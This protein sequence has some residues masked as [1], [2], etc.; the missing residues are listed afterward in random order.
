MY[1]T[2]TQYVYATHQVMFF[3][4]HLENENEEGEKFF[5]LFEVSVSFVKYVWW[6]VPSYISNAYTIQIETEDCGKVN[7]NRKNGQFFFFNL[8][9]GN[10]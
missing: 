10:D 1:N 3:I 5:W 6:S 8:T 2:I 7:E 4:C 9:A